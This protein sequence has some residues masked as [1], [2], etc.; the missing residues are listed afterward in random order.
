MPSLSL[1]PTQIRWQRFLRGGLVTPFADAPA[2]ATALV[3]VQAQMLPAAGVALWNRTPAFS[4]NTFESLIMQARTLVKLWGQRGTLHLYAS[5]DWP[6]LHA[7]RSI[8][9]T[10]WENRMARRGDNAE[11]ATA[12]HRALV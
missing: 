9:R 11:Q 8:N 4:H 5:E 2:A 10:W 7:A 3:G 1:T 12:Q 6:L